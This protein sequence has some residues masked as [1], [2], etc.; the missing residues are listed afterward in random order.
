MAMRRADIVHGASEGNMEKN[1][2]S[3]PY[4]AVNA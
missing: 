1:I 2:K 3:K 4:Y